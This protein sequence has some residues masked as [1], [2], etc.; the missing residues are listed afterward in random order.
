MPILKIIFLKKRLLAQVFLLLIFFFR[1]PLDEDQ[2]SSILDHQVVVALLFI[3][4]EERQRNPVPASLL[5]QGGCVEKCPLLKR[6]RG[7]ISLIISLR[8]LITRRQAFKSSGE[9]RRRQAQSSKL[10]L[11]PRMQILGPFGPHK[12]RV[13]INICN[14]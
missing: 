1:D 9:R 12:K 2:A 7:N 14:K 11:V 13:N 6:N 4:I 3:K 5:W 8:V 10:N